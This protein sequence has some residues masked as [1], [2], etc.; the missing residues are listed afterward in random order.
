MHIEFAIG[1]DLRISTT[2]SLATLC[3]RQPNALGEHFIVTPVYGNV[4]HT[5]L[6]CLSTNRGTVMGIGRLAFY[7]AE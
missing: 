7:P 6:Q 1:L 3:H 4:C 2:K 5:G